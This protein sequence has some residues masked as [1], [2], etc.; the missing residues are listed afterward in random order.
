MSAIGRK[1]S[2]R[3]VDKSEG[4]RRSARQDSR[5]ALFFNLKMLHGVASKGTLGIRESNQEFCSWN[6]VV[7]CKIDRQRFVAPRWGFRDVFGAGDP[8]RR[9]AGRPASLCR[10]ADLLWPFRLEIQFPLRSSAIPQSI[11]H[12]L[13]CRFLTVAARVPP[14]ISARLLTSPSV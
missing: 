4:L 12:A 13:L 14:V 8:G 11:F 1:L 10:W 3:I 2:D 6:L 5:S 7:S 9:F